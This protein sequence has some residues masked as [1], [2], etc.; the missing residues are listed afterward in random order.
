M[1]PVSP[2]DTESMLGKP[3]R[4]SGS[5][6]R[7]LEGNPEVC[8]KLRPAHGQLTSASDPGVDG[9]GALRGGG[10]SGPPQQELGGGPLPLPALRRQRRRKFPRPSGLSFACP[11]GSERKGNL[12]LLLFLTEDNPFRGEDSGHSR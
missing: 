4:R 10:V 2:L 6:P 5:N 11:L 8:R 9:G 7:N 12:P 3:F 1:A